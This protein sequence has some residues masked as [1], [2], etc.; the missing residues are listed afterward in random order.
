[1]S[2]QPAYPPHDHPPT[3][4]SI[5]TAS[6]VMLSEEGLGTR[7][8]SCLCT[9]N[10]FDDMIVL[11]RACLLLC[12]HF[13]GLKTNKHILGVYSNCHFQ[14]YASHDHLLLCNLYLCSSA[15]TNAHIQLDP[16]S[17]CLNTCIKGTIRQCLSQVDSC[18]EFKNRMT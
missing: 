5:S 1:M 13:V 18:V 8:C 16:Y 12:S 10:F 4:L 9:R 2:T 7:P 17:Y 14:C 11:V 15:M 6:N 3:Q